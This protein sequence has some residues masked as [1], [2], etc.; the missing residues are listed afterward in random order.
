VSE[1]ATVAYFPETG[2]PFIY[3]MYPGVERLVSGHH[4]NIF[5]N[6]ERFKT[7]GVAQLQPFIKCP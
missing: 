7:P 5:Y 6:S 2:P 3:K 4:G 1:R